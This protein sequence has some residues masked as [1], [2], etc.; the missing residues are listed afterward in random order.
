MCVAASCIHIYGLL[1]YTRILVLFISNASVLYAYFL[2]AV[3]PNKTIALTKS[4]FLFVSLFSACRVPLCVRHK[5]QN[6]PKKQTKKMDPKN[7]YNAHDSRCVCACG[8]RIS[9]YWQLKKHLFLF[10]TLHHSN[11]QKNTVCEPSPNQPP[12]TTLTNSITYS[13]KNTSTNPPSKKRYI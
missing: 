6:P 11:K 8:R 2:V 3:T 13:S 4:H 9:R 1:R 7:A 5:T 12:Q 10:T